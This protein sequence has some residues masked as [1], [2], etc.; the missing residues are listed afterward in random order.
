MRI[1]MRGASEE[2]APFDN[3]EFMNVALEEKAVMDFLT[4]R[5][6]IREDLLWLAFSQEEIDMAEKMGIA[7]AGCLEPG[8]P[9]YLKTGYVL[10]DWHSVEYDYLEKIYQRQKG[11]PWLIGETKRCYLRE[12]SMSDMDALVELYN[13]PGVTDFIEPLYDYDE[14][15]KYQQDYIKYMY[16]YYEYGMWLVFEKYTGRLIGRAGLEFREFDQGTRL[17]MGYVIAP[18][19]QRQGYATEICSFIEQY[20]WGH[21]D[22][23]NIL[24][25]VDEENTAS[26]NLLK[27]L[28][29]SC[30]GQTQITGEKMNKYSKNRPLQGL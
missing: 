13:K 19:Y 14:E 3:V 17:E 20:A 1:I 4:E 22:F 2:L 7:V 26:I 8:H 5:N 29:F 27:K 30:E 15:K 6:L 24:C 11:L 21:T 16:G 23:D 25:L 12:F 9:I 28:G 18:E 10:E